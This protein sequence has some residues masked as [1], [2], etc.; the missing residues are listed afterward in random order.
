LKLDLDVLAL[1]AEQWP[2]PGSAPEAYS[3]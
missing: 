3:W 2:G 1:I